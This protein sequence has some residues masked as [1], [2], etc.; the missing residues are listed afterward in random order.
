MDRAHDPAQGDRSPLGQGLICSDGDGTAHTQPAVLGNGPGGTKRSELPSFSCLC[1][2]TLLLLLPVE[3]SLLS[4]CGCSGCALAGCWHT[5]EA[6]GSAGAE[7][8]AFL[9]LAMLSLKLLWM[10]PCSSRL[11]KPALWGS[12]A[13][14]RNLCR[15]GNHLPPHGD[16]DLHLLC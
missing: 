15:G 6:A 5:A 3:R 16:K 10:P 14:D 11:S 1:L 2:L 8:A 13:L 7:G 9:W 12:A 4:P